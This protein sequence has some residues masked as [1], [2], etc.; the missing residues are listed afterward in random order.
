MATYQNSLTSYSNHSEEKFSCKNESSD[1][2]EK[3]ASTEELIPD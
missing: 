3:S 2:P 1:Y